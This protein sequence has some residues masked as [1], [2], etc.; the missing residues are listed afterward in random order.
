[1][2]SS[3]IRSLVIF[4]A[5]AG[6]ATVVAGRYPPMDEI[7]TDDFLKDGTALIA[8]VERLGGYVGVI[9]DGRIGIY[10]NPVGACVPLP[11]VPRWPDNVVDQTSLEL[12]LAMVGALNKAYMRGDTQPVYVL[13]K[14]RPY[15]K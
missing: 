1:M 14:C 8:K 7:S 2:K 13:D 5:G 9:K 3:V 6:S 4:A 12:G 10:S 11:P 15:A